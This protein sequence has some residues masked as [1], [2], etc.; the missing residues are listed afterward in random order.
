MTKPVARTS[1][2]APQSMGL[3]TEVIFTVECQ[4]SAKTLYPQG[5]PL[6]VTGTERFVFSHFIR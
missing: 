4:T 5:Q 6:E 3:V 1:L 2:D